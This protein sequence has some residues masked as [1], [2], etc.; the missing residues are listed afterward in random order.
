MSE[1]DIEFRNLNSQQRHEA[2]CTALSGSKIS[3]ICDEPLQEGKALEVIVHTHNPK[4]P[5]ITT[6]IETIKS[7]KNLYN[8]YEVDALIKIIKGT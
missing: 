2:R 4:N 6:Y 1:N 8:Q 5:Y 3:F 7:K